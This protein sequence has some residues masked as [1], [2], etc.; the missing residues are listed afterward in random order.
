[1]MLVTAMAI[2]NIPEGLSVG[3]GFASE[4]DKLGF[5]IALSIGLQNIPEGFLIALFLVHQKVNRF[6][7]IAVAFLTGGIEIAAGVLGFHLSAISLGIVPFGLAFAAGAILFIVYKE[8]I[9]ETHGHGYERAATF[10]FIVGIICMIGLVEWF[11]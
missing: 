10:S 11:R 7:A 6:T 9:P 2:H 3:A 8:L 5:L 4:A 1:V